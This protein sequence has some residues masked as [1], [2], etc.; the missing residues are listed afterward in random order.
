MA[1][2]LGVGPGPTACE[3]ARTP[4]PGRANRSDCNPRPGSSRWWQCRQN[5]ASQKTRVTADPIT[6]EGL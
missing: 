2:K 1:G 6:K 5:P 4:G 3:P